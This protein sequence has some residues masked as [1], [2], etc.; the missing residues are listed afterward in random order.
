ML[1]K[2]KS[3]PLLSIREIQERAR[4]ISQDPNRS[5]ALS[6]D[7]AACPQCGG[8]ETLHFLTLTDG[9]EYPIP[10]KLSPHL[11]RE[12]HPGSHL[13]ATSCPCLLEKQRQAR[14]D[15]LMSTGGVPRIYRAWSFRSWDAQSEA[16]RAGK[17]KARAYCGLFAQGTLEVDGIPRYGLVLSGGVGRGKTGLASCVLLERARR[18]ESVLWID[19]SKFIRKVRETY[20][21][22][23]VTSYEE[24][25]EAAASVPFLLLDDM[26]DLN[27]TKAISDDLR[28]NVYDVISERYNELLPTLITTNL[29]SAQFRATFG[30][31]I[32]D[33]VQHLY[34]WQG[35]GGTNLRFGGCDGAPDSLPSNCA[36]SQ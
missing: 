27:A 28:R 33:R 34:H 19:F 24:I 21:E 4:Q 31:R 2:P 29:S 13:S 9:T 17:E 32:A 26:G 30:D 12:D 3:R 5:P 7:P 36:D 23:S 18:G 25:I 20:R 1:R 15:R 6:L 35:V 11:V 14:L 22:N 8:S 10:P 16:E